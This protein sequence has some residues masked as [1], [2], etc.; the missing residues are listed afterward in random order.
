[1]LRN[2]EKHI[3]DHRPKWH[4]HSHFSKHM[5]SKQKPLQEWKRGAGAGEPAIQVKLCIRSGIKVNV[6]EA[7]KNDAQ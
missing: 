7:Q 4:R 6:N 2:K 3:W 5:E 1:M